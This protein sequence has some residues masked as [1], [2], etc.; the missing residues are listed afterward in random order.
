MDDAPPV[1]VLDVDSTLIEVHSENKE[2]AASHYKGGYG[3]HPMLC[4]AE[5]TGEAL[6]GMFRPGNAA[7]NSGADQLAVV[8]AAIASLPPERRTGHRPGDDPG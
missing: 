4:F 2:G 1:T 6:A 7:A 3:F 5:H 8:D